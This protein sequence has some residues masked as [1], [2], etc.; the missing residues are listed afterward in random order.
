MAPRKKKKNA[1]RELTAAEREAV[2]K[3]LARAETNSSVKLKVLNDT[4]GSENSG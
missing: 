2:G 1:L 4:G 3:Y